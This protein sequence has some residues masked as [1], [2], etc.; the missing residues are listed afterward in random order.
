MTAKPLARSYR[1]TLP[2]NAAGNGT[3]ISLVPQ[4]KLIKA[5]TPTPQTKRPRTKT[6]DK[7][8]EWI[9][10]CFWVDWKWWRR[11]K[12]KKYPVTIGCTV[13]ARP[14]RE[15]HQVPCHPSTCMSGLMPRMHQGPNQLT[16]AT[17]RGQTRTHTTKK[18]K[19]KKKKKKRAVQCSS[20]CKCLCTSSRL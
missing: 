15:F 13:P 17:P 2:I 10:V 8:C 11:R 9:G 18:K 16:A 14:H 1:A 6:G 5:N 12:K 19:K 3:P 7:V 4:S 20:S